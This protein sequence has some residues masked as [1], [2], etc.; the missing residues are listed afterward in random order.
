MSQI[1]I[2]MVAFDLDGTLLGRDRRISAANLEA[3]GKL[4]ARGIVS[5]LASGRSFESVRRLA[6]EYDLRGPIISNNGARLDLSPDGP[7]LSEHAFPDA[8]ARQV[9]A[10]LKAQKIYFTCYGHGT[11]YQNNLEYATDKLR[12]V[13]LHD[14]FVMHAHRAER[15]VD[16]EVLTV[17]EGLRAPY[18]FVAF[19]DHDEARN[20]LREALK[21]SGLSLNVSSS[22]H[23]NIEIMFA[24]AGKDVMLLEL[25]ARLSISRDKIMAFGDNTNDAGML[26]AAG[27]PVAMENAVP[28]LKKIA[29]LIAPD[30]DNDGVAAVLNQYVLE[31]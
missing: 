1:D 31:G 9:F 2:Q 21:A 7:M 16:D 18:K 5:V 24:E 3:I 29:S 6:A 26:Q 20:R 12:G 11:L 13:N 30:H 10:L 28:K 25:A 15:V 17:S 8:L 14:K 19:N 27:V 22:W 4:D 23:D